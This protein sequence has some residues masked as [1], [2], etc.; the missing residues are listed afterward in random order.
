MAG[1]EPGST[2]VGS[3]HSANCA[4]TNAISL[5]ISDRRYFTMFFHPS[6]N[7]GSKRGNRTW[8]SSGSSWNVY[9]VFPSPLG[10]AVV[11][12]VL[13]VVVKLNHS[14]GHPD[15]SVGNGMTLYVL[16]LTA[17]DWPKPNHI[18]KIKLESIPMN[19]PWNI[20]IHYNRVF[21]QSSNS[22]GFE[23]MDGDRPSCQWTVQ[24]MKIGQELREIGRQSQKLIWP[25]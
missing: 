14:G 9:Q 5:I 2:G 10:E 6:K 22:A 21:G 17:Y 15:I 24:S 20:L 12:V 7:L 3:N 18:V 11:V 4:T 16:Q 1:Y 13:V 19:P 23:L 25:S 8:A